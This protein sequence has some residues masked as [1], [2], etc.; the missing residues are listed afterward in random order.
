MAKLLS[1]QAL[2]GVAALLV[3]AFHAQGVIGLPQFGGIKPFA[4]FFEFGHAGVDFFFVLSGFIIFYIHQ[5][6]LNIPQ[7]FNSYLWKRVTRIYPLFLV[8]MLITALKFVYHGN[9]NTL[10]FIKTIFL[11]PQP[12]LPMLKQSWTL[13]HEFIFYLCFSIAFFNTRLARALLGIWFTAFVIQKSMDFHLPAGFS[14]DCLN[15]LSS[16]YNLLFIIGMLVAW[17]VVRIQ[18][19]FPRLFI[20]IGTIL[21]LLTGVAE[22]L[23]ILQTSAT[24]TILMFGL[25]SAV[26]LIGVVSGESHGLIRVHNSANLLGDLS[27]PLYLSH[28]IS[29]A[30][31]MAIYTI[32]G[33]HLPGWVLLILLLIICSIAGIVLNKLVERPMARMLKAASER[34]RSSRAAHYHAARAAP[35]L[36]K[37]R[38]NPKMIF[39]DQNE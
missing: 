28:G 30:A 36:E 15:V 29:I 22:N 7:R 9:F 11:L 16:P 27:Y 39:D 2:R 13:V 3:V 5:R 31:I 1:V 25:S 4:G 24:F 23:Q 12:A 21:F 6:E 33:L 18:V 14:A 17:L 35:L 8:V 38:S 37:R 26:L 34:W 10:D 32:S 19:P 20:I